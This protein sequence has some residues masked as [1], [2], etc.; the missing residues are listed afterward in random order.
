MKAPMSVKSSFHVPL[1]RIAL[2]A[3]TVSALAVAGPVLAQSS[4]DFVKGRL[5]V[6]P[7]AGL[8]DVNLQK[9]LRS[10][11]AG[12][13][14]K[15]GSGELRIVDLPVGTEQSTLQRLAHHPHLKFAE[16][17]RIVKIEMA[18]NDPYLGSEWHL[19]KTNAPTAWDRALGR[20]VTIA[21]L[22]TGVESSHPDL[23][24]AMVPGWNFYDNNSNTAD[25]YGHGTAV[26]GTAAAIANNAQGV[27]GVAG[28][29]KIMP[30]RIC[31]PSGSATYSAMAQGL[32]W[33]VDHGAR[34]ANISYVAA[35]SS[36]VISAAQYMKSKG[37]LVTTS[38]G[39][40]SRDMGITPTTALIPV[41]A[42]ESNDALASWSSWGAFVAVSAPGSG[43]YTTTTGASYG[44]MSGTSFSA[45]VTAGVIALMMSANPT[46]SSSTIESMLYSTA[47]DLGA[48]GRDPYFG[49]GRVDAAAAVQAAAGSTIA[50]DTTPPTTSIAAP[51]SMSSVSGLVG[52]DVVAADNV[53]VVKVELLVNNRVVATDTAAPYGFSWDS[54]TAANG[55]QSIVARAYD[56]AGNVGTS[57]AVTVTVANNVPVDVTA[58]D[59]RFTS[60][61]NGATVSGNTTISTSATDD[62]GAAG[63][64]QTLYIN[65][66]A[67][68]S[69]Q[70]GSLSYRWNTRKVA[71]GSY[72]LQVVASDAAG[73]TSTQS[74][75]VRR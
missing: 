36:A 59:V 57:T 25:V 6:M 69:T 55:S 48:P 17:D 54:T 19:A 14:R 56:A 75:T 41:S 65:G 23:A 4:P 52:V 30:I 58:P 61:G 33:A 26:A 71:P 73:N 38:A 5:L 11:G 51:L 39:N 7:R 22:D 1:R 70:G 29:A 15:V 74:I 35:D 46:L 60:P 50:A 3:W 53:G 44:S 72:T 27:S 24:A 21:I 40:Y 45:P 43:I 2:A 16:L 10:N 34:V 67:V 47:V 42:T 37:G 63:I 9:I 66:A 18:T 68:S 31:D 20:G 32:T 64:S 12:Q 62:S 49:Y 13:G 28:A 8:S